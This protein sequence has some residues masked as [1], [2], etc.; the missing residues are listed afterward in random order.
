MEVPENPD[1]GKMPLKSLSAI[2]IHIPFCRRRC[3]YCNFL[4]LKYEKSSAE[5]YVDLLCNELKLRKNVKPVIDTIYFGGGSPAVIPDGS[6]EKIIES[7]HENFN[8]ANISEMTIEINPEECSPEKLLFLKGMGFNRI[9]IGVQSFSD[10][11]LNYLSRNHNGD[12][13][14]EAVKMAVRTGFVSVSTDLIIGLPDQK[15]E[16]LEENI[17]IISSL[18]VDHISA[19]L[20]EGVREYG[21][22]K[23]PDA[24]R[25]SYLYNIF[26]EKAPEKGF[27][28]Y[29]I[30]SFCHEGNYSKHNMNYWNGGGYIGAGLSASGY[31]NGVDYKN[32]STLKN[33]YKSIE[34]MKFPVEEIEKNDQ[35][36]RSLV[37]GLRLTNG[38]EK[39]KVK[40]YT[41]KIRELIEEGFLEETE[42]YFSVAP[43]RMVVLNEIL[44]Y[45]I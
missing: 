22:R 37:T 35:V 9:S 5:R 10:E 21:G 44:S 15:A 16:T 24:D 4:K 32:Y 23:F 34:N 14:L 20:L 17:K 41:K 45:L 2:Y 38:I 31:E 18:G 3:Y 33:Y 7:L 28:Q 29:E 43:S 19:Y 8:T 40:P 1:K 42:D 11:D 39:W 27:E 25:Q 36:K 12:Q 6:M 13:S 30:S 26:R